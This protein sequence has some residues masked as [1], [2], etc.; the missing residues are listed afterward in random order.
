[1]TARSFASLLAAAG[2]LGALVA[3][4][5][6]A[7]RTRPP[8][9]DA[10]WVMVSVCRAVGDEK[11]LTVKAADEL[12]SRVR[13]DLP[14]KEVWT[15]PKENM[16]AYL[17]SSGFSKTEPLAPHDARALAQ[18]LRASEYVT[19]TVVKDET[20][21]RMTANMVHIR[22]NSLVQPLGSG[23]AN[24]LGD[25]TKAITAEYKEARKQLDHEQA[26]INAAR[27]QK[28]DE[29][30]AAA[31]EGI[32]AY[33]NAVL[34]R[35][36]LVNV[37]VS[38]KASPDELLAASRE[39]VD[40]HPSDRAGLAIKAQ[41]FRDLD[42]Q[43]SAITTLTTLLSTDPTNA[44]L[45]KD[46]IDAI[47]AYGNPRIARPIVEQAVANNPGDPDL[48]RLRWL[49]LLAVRDFK[50]AFDAGEDLV[51]LDTAF[52]DT[53]YF[54][55]TA[56]AYAVDSQPQK[57]AE[58][59]ARGV[60]KFPEHP[61][62]NSTLVVALR[63][64]GQNQQALEVL[65]RAIA[66]G[67]PVDNGGL[68]EVTLLTDL[69]QN[70]AALEASRRAV[71]RG[72]SSVA[73]AVFAIGAKAYQAA[74]ESKALEDYQKS[75]ELLAFADSIGKGETKL[76]S[77]YYYGVANLQLGQA[78]IQQAAEAKD[79]E[80]A[81]AAK[82]NFVEA[83]ISLPAGGSVAPQQVP[84]LMQGLMQLDAYADQVIAAI[85]K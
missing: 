68:L 33:P 2:V 61:G 13:Q 80:M 24:K 65:Q 85:C 43:D 60:A 25:V 17:E 51:R 56:A 71:A 67:V 62:L 55:R 83:Q 57:A 58:T 30:I 81:K 16:E 20:G 7:Q 1:M 10:D 75:I 22:D 53:T 11:N 35:V 27:E 23:E 12:R 8:H 78:R 3:P 31:R 64:S 15:I 36:C 52:A 74:G 73:D 77:K 34:A 41:A 19:C 9:P 82:D 38:M 84:Q 44:R 79:C 4:Q 46:V 70:E 39:L 37:M 69:G 40:L 66:N 72:D 29:A 54:I 18:L 5:A 21:Y 50:E 47:T 63:Q 14:F 48:M 49:I 32:A 76:R 42:M 6:E 28:W 45:Q 59:A 26:C